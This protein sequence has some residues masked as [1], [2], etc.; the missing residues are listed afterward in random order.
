MGKSKYQIVLELVNKTQKQFSTINKSL[1]KVTAA[2]GRT[3]KGFLKA[4]AAVTGTAGAF[5]FLVKTQV[6]AIDKLDKVSQKLGINAEFLQ[7][8]RFAAQQTGV[9]QNTLDMALQRFIRRAGEAA[10]NTG[11]AQ[12]AL[13]KLGI[14]LRD[15]E[16]NL[17]SAKDLLFDVADGLKNTK[18]PAEQLRL[19]FKF[20]DSEGAALVNT[21]NKGSEELKEFFRQAERLGFILDDA[22]VAGVA[23]FNDKLG[24]LQRQ[25]TGFVQYSVAALVPVLE[26]VTDHFSLM[27]EAAAGGGGF[28]KLGQDIVVSLIG[29]LQIVVVTIGEIANALKKISTFG[30]GEDVINIQALND[31]MEMAKV[32][33]IRGF[34]AINKAAQGS[35]GGKTGLSAT[36]QSYKDSLGEFSVAMDNVAVNTMKKFEDSIVDG[37]MKGKLAFKDFAKFVVEQLVRVAVQQI[38]VKR[39]LGFGAN[40]FGADSMIGKGLSS[41]ASGDG[42]GFTGS[43]SRTGGIDGK[44]GFPAILHP[45][46]TVIDHT[47]GQGMGATVNFN[48]NTVD[49]AGF[50]K[51]LASRK[52]TI[53][54]IINNAMNNQGKMGVV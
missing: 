41:M 51:L 42:G 50:D 36:L 8:M 33:V 37:L 32:T 10:Q 11:E 29:A 24:I 48:I 15:N 54:Q 7:K 19:A 22:T 21:L 6:D 14:Q 13:K 20:F 49:A 4:T 18:D 31:S 3:A 28:A 27:L 34:E 39:L 9:A 26:K 40:L 23:A 46:E 44:G 52:G 12:G 38:L 30:F 47:K 2:T 45:N 17:R 35:G 16:G 25:I 1:K 5:L 53:T 43:G